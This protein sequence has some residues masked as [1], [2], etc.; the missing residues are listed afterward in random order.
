[1]NVYG[2]IIHNGIK[3]GSNSH[4]H[5]LVNEQ[6]VV[7]Y[8]HTMEYYL[9]IKINAILKHVTIWMNLKNLMLRERSKIQNNYMIPL[10]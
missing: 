8:I 2:S 7:V 4:F 3:T 10:T 1:M 9:A 5:Q 6:N